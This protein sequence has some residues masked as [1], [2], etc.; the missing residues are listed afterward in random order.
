MINFYEGEI[1]L[2]DKPK[3]W[4][5]FDVV[6]KIRN[7]IRRKFGKKLKVGHAGTLDPLA[8]GLLIIGT[9]KMTKKLVNYSD[10]NKEYI[11][12]IKFGVTTPTYD[13]E[14]EPD[15]YFEYK[16]INKNLFEQK[17]SEFEGKQIQVPPKYSAKKINGKKACVVARKGEKIYM[18]PNEVEFKKIEILELDLPQTATVKMLV[19][20]GTYIRSFA[21]DL[22][23]KLNTG[24]ILNKLRRTKIGDFYVNK[25]FTI[26]NVEK[27]IKNQQINI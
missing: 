4:T 13:K 19:S 10:L 2:I 17:I 3:E 1:L 8:S 24:A 20:K 16:H 11:A 27:F 7:I 12:Q 25:A 9:G 18:R 23:I 14:S 21:H 5:S 15:K 26:E 6:N 22:G